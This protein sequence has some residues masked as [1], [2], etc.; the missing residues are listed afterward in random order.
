M[1]GLAASVGSISGF[2]GTVRSPHF[3]AS[4]RLRGPSPV[5]LMDDRWMRRYVASNRRAGLSDTAEADHTRAAGAD[6]LSPLVNVSERRPGHGEEGDRIAA[7]M[8]ASAP[9]ECVVGGNAPAGRAARRSSL[10]ETSMPRQ[11]RRPQ[12][13]PRSETC[14]PVPTPAS[15]QHA[16]D[17]L[18]SR[19][20]GRYHLPLPWLLLVPRPTASHPLPH[21]EQG[22]ISRARGLGEV[23]F[24]SISARGDARHAR[25]SHAVGER[26]SSTIRRTHDG[27][28]ALAG[29]R[30]RLPPC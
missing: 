14:A 16:A 27:R 21:R 5:L 7:R 25:A 30:C 18:L 26:Q 2:R 24:A 29:M 6:S 13:V 10:G 20:R 3:R 8:F 22:R 17:C 12:P 4:I 23:A 19:Q 15:N 1:G 9:R 28:A 11:V